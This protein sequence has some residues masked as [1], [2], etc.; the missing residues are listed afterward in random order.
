MKYVLCYVSGI[1]TGAAAIVLLGIKL[2][3][4]EEEK[5]EQERIRANYEKLKEEKYSDMWN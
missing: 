2:D 1:I 3:K 4:E 5:K